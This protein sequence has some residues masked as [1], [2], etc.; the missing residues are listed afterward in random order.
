M[1]ARQ[2]PPVRT[3]SLKKALLTGA[4]ALDCNDGNVCTTDSCDVTNGCG[5]TP[6][7]GTSCDDG[8]LCTE[9]DIATKRCRTGYAGLR[10]QHRIFADNTVVTDMHKVVDTH[11]FFD[12][13]RTK[14]CPVNRTRGTY[15]HVVINDDIA[16]LIDLDMRTAL[17]CRK[18]ESVAS[19]HS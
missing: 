12:M 15:L 13:R 5:S 2:A 17:R 1:T 10:D 11:T 6:K 9:N 4:G 8:N 18:T 3:A 7:T 19:D 16:V 14:S